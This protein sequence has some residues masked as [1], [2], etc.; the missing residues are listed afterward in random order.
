MIDL[1]RA[2]QRLISLQ[3]ADVMAKEVVQMRAAHTMAEIAHTLTDREISGI[4]ITDESRHCV[5]LVSGRDFVKRE[6]GKEQLADSP[7]IAQTHLTTRVQTISP[8][9]PLVAAARMMTDQHFH[10]LPVVDSGGHPIGILTASDIV[11]ALVNAI[12]ETTTLSS[13]DPCEPS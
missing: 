13:A 4:V 10:R 7:D 9:T 3:V 5:G 1:D 2:I 8:N 6:S 11:A 12:D